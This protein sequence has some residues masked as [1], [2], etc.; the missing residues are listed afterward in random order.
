MTE[1]SVIESNKLFVGNLHRHVRWQELKEYFSQWGE[2]EY[3][4]VAL[5]RETKKSRWFG[6][7][8]FVNAA[9]AEKA[10]MEAN[11]KELNGR[12]IYVDFA[13]AREENGSDEMN[14]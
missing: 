4:S 9:D 11:E 8:T 7:V 12:V 6:F 2:V 10:K 5:D 13:R 3:A 14:Q 1:Q